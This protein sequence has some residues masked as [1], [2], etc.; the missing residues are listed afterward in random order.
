MLVCEEI[1]LQAGRFLQWKIA[2]LTT[3]NGQA[4]MPH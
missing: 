4:A 3:E 2:N 1:A